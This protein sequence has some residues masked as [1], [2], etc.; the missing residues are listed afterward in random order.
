MNINKIEADFGYLSE[1]YFYA[2]DFVEKNFWTSVP[3]KYLHEKQKLF[4]IQYL[5]DTPHL[6]EKI[7]KKINSLFLHVYFTVDKNPLEDSDFRYEP[8]RRLGCI[9]MSKLIVEYAENSFPELNLN[10]LGNSHK[11]GVT[12]E[13]LYPEEVKSDSIKNKYMCFVKGSPHVI[14]NGSYNSKSFAFD[15]LGIDFL[16]NKIAQPLTQVFVANDDKTLNSILHHRYFSLEPWYKFQSKDRWMQAIF[17]KKGTPLYEE[18]NVFSPKSE[19][20]YPN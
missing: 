13:C 3:E 8:C 1:V 4:Y 5:H 10:M 17:L 6:D 14:G 11:I 19:A 2:S 12:I 18:T 20:F 7:V 16:C 15:S 9:T